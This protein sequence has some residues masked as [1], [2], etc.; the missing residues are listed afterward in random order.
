MAHYM[1]CSVLARRVRVIPLGDGQV[2]V[3]IT[4]DYWR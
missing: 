3:E 2:V 1:V 4:V